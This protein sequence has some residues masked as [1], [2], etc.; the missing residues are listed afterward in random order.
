M[1]EI[2]KL[3]QNLIIKKIDKETLNVQIT[4]NV[5]LMSIVGQFDQNL[6]DLENLTSTKIFFRG[7]SMF[8]SFPLLTV[9]HY[10]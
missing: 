2:T 8:A 7:N 6:K 9:Q 3:D 1:S 5:M 4:D 10:S